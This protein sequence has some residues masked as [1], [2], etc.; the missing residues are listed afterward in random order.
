[1]DEL[2]L[3]VEDDPGIRDVT[4]RGL[5]GAGFKVEAEAD[6]RQALVRFRQANFDLV[7]LDLM[8]P[9]LGGVEVCRFIRAESTVP[10]VMLTAKSDTHDVVLGL[11]VGA[12]DYMTKPFEMPELIARLRAVLRRTHTPQDEGK[13]IVGE[14]EIDGEAFTATKGGNPLDLTTTEFRLLLELARSRGKVKSRESLLESV[15]DYDYLGDS[16]I[17]DMAVKRLRD[18][19]E[20]DPPDPKWIVTIRG[21]G[22]KFES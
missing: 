10:V 8:L 22:Y 14:L 16:R 7:L 11:E 12:D 2:I 19:I 15:W 4:A 5:E 21:V 1:M 18:K 9:S 20:D 13:I 17:V 3:F 6:G